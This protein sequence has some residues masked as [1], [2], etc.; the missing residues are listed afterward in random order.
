MR[1]RIAGKQT[2]IR[3]DCIAGFDGCRETSSRYL[4]R[5]APTLDVRFAGLKS[6][7]CFCVR[8]TEALFTQMADALRVRPREDSTSTS[9]RSR[10]A[11]CKSMPVCFRPWQIPPESYERK[12]EG[13][14]Q[15]RN[16]RC[17]VVRGPAPYRQDLEGHRR[18]SN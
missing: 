7:S 11:N 3:H 18:P 9:I 16:Q 1:I 10:T 12:G 17:D 6:H 4:R 2:E 15:S 14:H 5:T 13:V 8:V